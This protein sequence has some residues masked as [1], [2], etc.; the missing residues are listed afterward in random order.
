MGP[1]DWRSSFSNP[2]HRAPPLGMSVSAD[3][4]YLA[5]PDCGVVLVRVFISLMRVA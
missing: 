4:D 1:R 3:G 5:A 2:L